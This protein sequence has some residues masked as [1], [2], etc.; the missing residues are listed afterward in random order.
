[1]GATANSVLETSLPQEHDETEKKDFPET[2]RSALQNVLAE[3][4]VSSKRF[5]SFLLGSVPRRDGSGKLSSVDAL[6]CL[7][8]NNPVRYG[9]KLLSAFVDAHR[10]QTS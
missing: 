2:T 4:R 3:S 8:P 7:K 1:M 9:N 6:F 5:C 10:K